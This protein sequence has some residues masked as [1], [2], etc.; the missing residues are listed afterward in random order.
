MSGPVKVRP[1]WKAVFAGEIDESKLTINPKFSTD[2]ASVLDWWKPKAIA[3]YQ[4]KLKEG[5]IKDSSLFYYGIKNTPTT[6][7]SYEQARAKHLSEVGR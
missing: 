1:G 4:K 3:H 6:S 5:R 2:V 7:V